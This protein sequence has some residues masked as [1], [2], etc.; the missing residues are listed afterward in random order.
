M[1]LHKGGLSR[2]RLL[3]V[4]MKAGGAILI[5]TMTPG[6]ARAKLEPSGFSAKGL[7]AVTTAMQAAIDNGDAAGIVTL[8][9][10]HGAIAQVNAVGFQ[11]EAA[12]TPMRRDTIFRIASMT[13]PIVA[14]AILILIEEGRLALTMPVEKFLPELA[15]PK[16]LRNPTDALATA[17]P[18]PRGITVLDLLTHRSGICTP[19]TAPGPLVTGLKDADA[20]REIG[21]DEWIKRIGALPL[22]YEPGSRFNYGNSFDVLGVLV[23][24]ASGMTLPDFLEA[25]IF[26]PL[27]MKD[28]GFFVPADKTARFATNYKTDPQTK[29]RIVADQPGATSRWAKPPAFPAGAGGLVSTADDYLSFAKMLLGKG[30]SGDVRILSHESVVLMTSN[31]LSAEQRKAPFSGFEFWA[32]QGFGL[33]VSVVDDV[34]R[35]ARSPFGF[36]SVGSFGWPGAFG[37]WWQADPKEDM[38]QIFMVQMSAADPRSPVRRFQEAGYRAIDD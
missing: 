26:K 12:K 25:R 30:R 23:A 11:D 18:S 2:R 28:S 24:R 15:S 37:T 20:A 17:Q 38:I 14:V 3:D 35:Q 27:G 19:D 6:A 33:G 13:K 9:Y 36:S 7:K 29:M 22:A 5:G 8:L 16:L 31:E 10:R 34:A 4:G 1:T 32:G 21:P